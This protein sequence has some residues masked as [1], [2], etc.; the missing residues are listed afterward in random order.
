MTLWVEIPILR[1]L[2]LRRALIDHDDQYKALK[3]ARERVKEVQKRFDDT[4]RAIG[5]K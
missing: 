2:L 1:Q 5:S 4:R 3:K